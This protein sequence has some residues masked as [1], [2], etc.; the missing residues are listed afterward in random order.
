MPKSC[1]C[2]PEPYCESVE[3]MIDFTRK[4]RYGFDDF[5]EVVRLL[6][7]PEGCPWD[8]V[9]TH[10]S[11]RRNFL[12]EVYECCEALDTDDAALMQEELGDVLMQV[13]FHAGIEE[14]RGRFNLD[15]IC[16]GAVKKLVFRHPNVFGPK[17]EQTWDDM[18]ALEKG[19]KTCA[20]TLDAVARSLPALWRA[21]KLVK[22]AEK[23]GF[24]WTQEA[25]AAEKLQEAVSELSQAVEDSSNIE[26]KLGDVL[27]SAV[28]VAAGTGADPEMALH[29]ACETFITRFAAMEQAAEAQGR[30]LETYSLAEQLALWQ[31]TKHKLRNLGQTDY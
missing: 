23:A 2:G 12:E 1:G 5:V 7:S 26:E 21:E 6:R 13:I 10:Q 19:Q 18:K 22:K 29:S 9:Q 28:C 17:T 16:D 27:F 24:Q 11:I 8:R 30:S 20:A 3:D 14:D 31:D 25:P 4:S 15:D